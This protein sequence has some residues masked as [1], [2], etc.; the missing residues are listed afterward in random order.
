MLDEPDLCITL[1]SPPRRGGSTELE[2][3]LA[4]V[5]EGDTAVAAAVAVAMRETAEG[6]GW[7]DLEVAAALLRDAAAAAELERD[8]DAMDR[9]VASL[10]RLC[11][12]SK[13]NHLSRSRWAKN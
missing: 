5:A 7:T 2:G 9:A 11:E 3:L 8:C 12:G 6:E 4:A 1:D 13:P 10:A